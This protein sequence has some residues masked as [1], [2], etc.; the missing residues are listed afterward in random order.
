MRG[1]D[2]RRL[3]QK[4]HSQ[5]W[6]IQHHTLQN[7]TSVPHSKHHVCVNF[8]WQLSLYYHTRGWLPCCIS[9]TSFTDGVTAVPERWL[10]RP[11]C[12]LRC[13]ICQSSHNPLAF[14]ADL[15]SIFPSGIYKVMVCQSVKCLVICAGLILRHVYEFITSTISLQNWRITLKMFWFKKTR[16][17]CSNYYINNFMLIKVTLGLGIILNRFHVSVNK[18]NLQLW[19]LE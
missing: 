19:V 6:L 10:T 7:H 1:P 12:S 3:E 14:T 8:P 5:V 2:L 18:I 15:S 4:L 16:P 11:V 17:I 9:P 13:L